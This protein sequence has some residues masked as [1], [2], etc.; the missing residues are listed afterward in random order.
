[1]NLYNNIRCKKTGPEALTATEPIK[2]G[3]FEK[4]PFY[5]VYP[6]FSGVYHYFHSNH[7][8]HFDVKRFTELVWIMVYELTIYMIY[9]TGI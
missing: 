7:G 8:V 1:M 4:R 2:K 6:R 3:R 5:K 9:Q